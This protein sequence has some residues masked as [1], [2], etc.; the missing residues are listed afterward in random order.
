MARDA[1][2]TPVSVTRSGTLYLL[3]RGDGPRAPARTVHGVT[4]RASRVL[5]L[6]SWLAHLTVVESWSEV[7][8]EAWPDA[9]RAV[10]GS[11]WPA[12]DEP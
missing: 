8:A 9:V 5:P 4:G 6:G 12:M 2:R 1:D 7:P 10:A 3:A 11:G